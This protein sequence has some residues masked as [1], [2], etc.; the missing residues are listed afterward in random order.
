MDESGLV[1]LFERY[2][3]EADLDAL[4]Q[5]FD[6]TAPQ[7]L[8]VARHL[9]RDEAQ[10]E[11]LVQAT[12]LAAIEHAERFDATR[13]L[14]PWLIGILTN[15]AKLARSLSDRAPDPERLAER[16][17]ED[18]AHDSE[19]RE[20]MA[21]LERAL[22]RVPDAYRQV[23]RIHLAEGKGA[24]EIAHEVKRPAGTVRVQ[25][26]RGLKAL[27]RLL[28]AGFAL[29]GVAVLSAPRGLAAIRAHVLGRAGAFAKAG[30]LGVAGTG[31][32]GG[33]LVGKKVAV[34]V[35][36]VVFALGVWRIGA[37]RIRSS[38]STPSTNPT[39][40]L[41]Q[42]SDRLGSGEKDAQ[43][44]AERVAVRE[45]ATSTAT[46]EDGPYGSLEVEVDWGDGSHAA[47]LSVQVIPQEEHQPD[48][49]AAFVRT[50][51]DGRFTIPRIHE[52]PAQIVLDRVL[53]FEK[54]TVLTVERGR[55]NFAKVV[56]PELRNV[57]GKV[58]DASGKPVIHGTVWAINDETLGS[59]LPVA[60]TAEDGSFHIRSI[61]PRLSIFATA[62]DLGS[63][64]AMKVGSL[65]S[66]ADGAFTAE[67][68]LIGE[69]STLD[70]LV[71]DAAGAPVARARVWT[72]SVNSVR[73]DRFVHWPATVVQTDGDGKFSVWGMHEPGARVFVDAQGFAV[74]SGFS[75]LEEGRTAHVDVK[76]EPGFTVSGTVK[77]E[78]GSPSVGVSITQKV[79]P[80]LS[81]FTPVWTSTDAEGGYSLEH[82]APGEVTLLAEARR[83]RGYP[84]AST[85]LTAQS[86][87]V[88]P[89]SPTLSTGLVIRGRAEDESGNPISGWHV[90]A[91]PLE[92]VQDH[93]N[94][95]STDAQGH[96]EIRGCAD[97]P[98]EVNLSA[99]HLSNGPSVTRDS[100]RPSDG[101]LVLVV[102][103]ESRA[104]ASVTGRILDAEGN[105]LALAEV[106]ASHR[107]RDSSSDATTDADGRF[108]VDSLI[109]GP[110]LVS[111]RISETTEALLGRVDLAADEVHDMGT[112]TIEKRGR[113]ELTL[114]REDGSLFQKDS[115]YLLNDYGFV[116]LA[117]TRDGVMF[118]SGD[119]QPGRYRLLCTITGTA[120]EMRA[121]QIQPGGTT[122]EEWTVPTG[123][124]RQI[125]FHVTDG[126]ARARR[127]RVAIR[128]SGGEIVLDRDCVVDRP[129][130]GDPTY[131]LIAGFA[132]GHYTYEATSKEGLGAI[133]SFDVADLSQSREA[134]E[135]NLVRGH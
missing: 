37:S 23:L 52:G 5:V 9:V 118:T 21:T 42:V 90:S 135:I 66:G 24:E 35:A 60:Q 88:V 59:G 38:S 83:T 62:R 57:E 102:T 7:L 51:E 81:A 19:L 99:P 126:G 125:E 58:I 32:A 64:E 45:A 103:N 29:G 127:L 82:L 109:P 101:D 130:I 96:F 41:E 49:H 54:A 97:G 124:L 36:L 78:D 3:G 47:G 85:T 134:M 46:P 61:H 65:S 40:G 91:R 14:V 55:R 77:G 75:K 20:F 107:D 108:R 39:A 44:S 48:Q 53:H 122:R 93:P 16:A 116:I 79:Q 87:E 94:S 18:P 34:V 129:Q 110:H 15:K 86:G 67:L 98:H 71:T 28:P 4:A 17:S 117:S 13:E 100:V 22:E 95:V 132:L 2:R 105:P 30:A 84:R 114:H 27:R 68:H 50:N 121:L 73:G 113:L 106:S 33:V 74:W 10:A 120:T 80:W 8:K 72:Q 12:F 26:H 128:R 115:V 43:L 123:T 6:L 70:G 69:D 133:G 104:S 119:V 63:S 11:D 31:I 131:T 76:M 25:L 89:W 56:A 92:D 111:V 1:E 112:M